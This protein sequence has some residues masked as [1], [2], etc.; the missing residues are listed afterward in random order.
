MRKQGFAAVLAAA[1]LIGLG[2][3]ALPAHAQ[4]TFSGSD[5]STIPLSV[6]ALGVPDT[7]SATYGGGQITL[8][9]GD[10]VNSFFD[11]AQLDVA[12]GFGGVALG[13]L[14]SFLASGSSFDL[15]SMA[16]G[17][18]FAYWDLVISNGTNIYHIN[19]YSDNTLG[20]NVIDA[21][22]GNGVS[23]GVTLAGASIPGSVIDSITLP[24]TA[25]TAVPEPAIAGI[26]GLRRGSTRLH[27]VWTPPWCPRPRGPSRLI[28]R[29]SLE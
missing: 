4:I 16:P 23:C 5:L 1:T 26:A 3:V 14:S 24:G 6:P 28:S 21:P 17:D 20:A 22:S 13:T 9:S 18:Q 15:V 10:N 2:L 8:S 27:P 29:V 19:S 7:G 25:L 12:N 11:T